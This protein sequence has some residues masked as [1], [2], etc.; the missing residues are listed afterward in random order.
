[1]DQG[2][3]CAAGQDARLA[4][5]EAELQA[6]RNRIFLAKAVPGRAFGEV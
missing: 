1:M 2:G 4:A 5:G 3:G 6:A